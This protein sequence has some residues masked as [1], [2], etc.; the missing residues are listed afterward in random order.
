M[1]FPK[2]DPNSHNLQNQEYLPISEFPNT[3]NLQNQEY[4]PMIKH[5][6]KIFL[7][8]NSKTDSQKF[9]HLRENM[10]NELSKQKNYKGQNHKLIQEIDPK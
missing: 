5:S 8:L 2:Q 4:I 7:N 10:K 9:S 3:Y 1:Y 6:Q